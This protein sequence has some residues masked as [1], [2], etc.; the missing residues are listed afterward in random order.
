MRR[1]TRLLGAAEAMLES[2]GAALEPVDRV[3]YAQSLASARSQL[4]DEQFESARQE[5]RA[6]SSE[7]AIEYAQ[8]HPE[9]I[10]ASVLAHEPAHAEGHEIGA[11]RQRQVEELHIQVNQAKKARQVEAI[12]GTEYFIE[13][14]AR[15]KALLLARR[16]KEARSDSQGQLP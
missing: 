6:M 15:A 3:P 1:G 16:Q 5:G 2:I 4:G 10:F 14:Q 9:G 8:R 12:T 11:E 13:L 7:E